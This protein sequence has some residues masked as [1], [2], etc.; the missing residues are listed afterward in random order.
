[1][2]LHRRFSKTL[3]VAI[4]IPI[5]LLSISFAQSRAALTANKATA[6]APKTGNKPSPKQAREAQPSAGQSLP[7]R[8]GCPPEITLLEIVRP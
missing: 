6:G 3:P 8:Y 1:M 4:A 5:L 7:L 2:R